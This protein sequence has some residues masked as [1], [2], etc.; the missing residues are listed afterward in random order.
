MDYGLQLYSVRDITDKDFFGALEEVRKIGYKYI[1]PA[2]FFGHMAEEVKAKCDEL[3]FVVSGSHSGFQDLLDR[4]DETV[5]YHKAIGNKNYIIPGV[6]LS[7][8]A[9]VDFFIEKINELQPRLAAEGIT[10]SYHN[11]DGEFKPNE[12]GIIPYDEIVARTKIGLEIDTYW[13]YAAGKDP[14]ALMEELKDRL[15]FIHIKD[16]LADRTGKPLGLGTAPVKAVY[17]K[18]A[19]LGVLMVVESE[20][21][22]PDGLTEARICYE[23][24]KGLEG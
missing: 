3:G 20:T 24:L 12:D 10:V 16:G 2:G 1:E 23:Y 15:T 5:A 6:K 21:L 4:F 22:K 13:A 9:D 19:E 18:A 14:V 8:K 7:T 11:H 17:A